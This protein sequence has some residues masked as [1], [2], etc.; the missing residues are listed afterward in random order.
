MEV[1]YVNNYFMFLGGNYRKTQMI[2]R[3][4]LFSAQLVLIS[5]IMQA[6]LGNFPVNLSKFPVD[7]VLVSPKKI[8]A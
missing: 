2:F 5:I 6:I 7:I 1:E 3:V 8:M 4:W